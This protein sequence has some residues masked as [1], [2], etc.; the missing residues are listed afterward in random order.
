L[1][2]GFSAG[3]PGQSKPTPLGGSQPR[4]ASAVYLRPVRLEPNVC[5]IV[6]FEAPAEK[7][8]D[9]PSRR[10]GPRLAQGVPLPQNVTQ[11]PRW[12]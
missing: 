8:L 4:Q 1:R 6:V 9:L 11:R 5:G 2:A 3:K 10:M 12:R 7:V